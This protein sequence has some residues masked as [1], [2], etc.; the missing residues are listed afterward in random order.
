M[1]RLVAPLSVSMERVELKNGKKI[2]KSYNI[3]RIL[4]CKMR[5]QRRLGKNEGGKKEM[6]TKIIERVLNQDDGGV[7][8]TFS[9]KYMKKKSTCRTICTEYLLN[10]GGRS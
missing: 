4:P 3:S 6:K 9:H 5:E 8:L 2:R 7:E 1:E 10:S